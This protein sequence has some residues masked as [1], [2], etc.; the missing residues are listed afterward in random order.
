M[1]KLGIIGYPVEH[2]L[3]PILHQH[4]LQQLQ[5]EGSYEK[6]AI[7]EKALGEQISY[8]KAMGYRGF[9]VTI[10]HK[11][12]VMSY[13]EGIDNEAKVIGA[14]NTVSLRGKEFWGSNTDSAG[15]IRAVIA[16]GFEIEGK[17]ALV[18]GA[19]G[20]GR[21]VVYSLIRKGIKKLF[22]ANRTISRAEKLIAEIEKNTNF[23]KGVLTAIDFDETMLARYLNLCQLV[24]NAT[25]VGMRP[26]HSA[27]PYA[28]KNRVDDLLVADVVYNPLETQFL[29]S[30]RRAGAQVVDGLDMLIYQA[31][32]AMRIWLDSPAP[33]SFDYEGLRALLIKTLEKHGT[34]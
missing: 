3:S 21:A 7:T 9:N 19:G 13:L 32:A 24:V 22:L 25:S 4:L 33:I 27:T 8:L 12:R 6:F 10:P 14:V 30:A 18:L 2:S 1:L 11:Q 29:K 26:E 23:R 5:V 28:F 34:H 16:D 17:S 15:F 20:A 31:V